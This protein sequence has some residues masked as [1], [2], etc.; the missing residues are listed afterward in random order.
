MTK[1]IPYLILNF[2]HSELRQLLFVYA[3]SRSCFIDRFF[4]LGTVAMV[5]QDCEQSAILVAARQGRKAAG[6]PMIR[7]MSFHFC[8][9]ASV[10][11]PVDV[12][13]TF[14]SSG[15]DALKMGNFLVEK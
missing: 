9:G 8:G 4:F 6:A 5:T 1:P 2:F 11:T 7:N 14:F 3:D 15:I 10:H 13:H 12:G